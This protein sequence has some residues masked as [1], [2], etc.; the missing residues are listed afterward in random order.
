LFGS[1]GFVKI[2]VEIK[3]LGGVFPRNRVAR[4]EFF[5][6]NR[7]GDFHRTRLTGNRLSAAGIA[8]GFVISV[9]LLRKFA[10][11]VG[12]LRSFPMCATFSRSEYYDRTDAFCR[13]SKDAFLSIPAK[14]LPRSR[15]TKSAKRFRWRL[16]RDMRQP[17][18]LG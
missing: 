13:T 18:P 4:P 7:A 14:S 8:S 11:S 3:K 5:V 1:L 12:S 10:E 6:L 9:K 2:F 15:K 16:I 17:S